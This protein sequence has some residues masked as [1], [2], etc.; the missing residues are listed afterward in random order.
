[1]NKIEKPKRMNVSVIQ[2]Y[3]KEV[4]EVVES[5]NEPLQSM[6]VFLHELYMGPFNTILETISPYEDLIRKK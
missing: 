5:F 1:L 2:N 4:K 3:Y 6:C